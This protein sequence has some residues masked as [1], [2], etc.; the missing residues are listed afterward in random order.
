MMR[1]RSSEQIFLDGLERVYRPGATKGAVLA[2]RELLA[3]VGVELADD[4]SVPA[5]KD[6]LLLL[7][8]AL[9]LEGAGSDGT[10]GLWIKLCR[11][12]A[13]MHPAIRASLRI[14]LALMVAEKPANLELAARMLR[15]PDLD[16][17]TP[18]RRLLAAV[19]RLDGRTTA[20]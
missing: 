9:M 1:G 7:A 3:S 19:D 6:P 4:L 17:V 5:G 18:L 8:T 15:A 11:M 13:G 14:G 20:T 12:G 16:L 10:V 2:A